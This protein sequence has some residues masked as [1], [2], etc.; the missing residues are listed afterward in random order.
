MAETKAKPFKIIT[1]VKSE[2]L[3]ATADRLEGLWK[4]Q[5]ES[6]GLNLVTASKRYLFGVI[7]NAPVICK[8]GIVRKLDEIY[9]IDLAQHIANLVVKRLQSVNL[10]PVS[11]S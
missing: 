10:K 11:L 5:L 9:T 7:M 4:P 2:V 1:T 8:D 3:Y 6:M